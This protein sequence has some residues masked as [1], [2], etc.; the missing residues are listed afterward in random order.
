[1]IDPHDITNFNRTNGELQEFLLFGICAAGK[2]AAIQA[3][4]LADF[5]QLSEGETPFEKV[6]RMIA[7]GSLEDNLRKVKL[8]KYRI[9]EPGFR[10]LAEDDPDLETISEKGLMQYTGIGQKT[11]KFFLLHSREDVTVA[12]LDTHVLAWLRE[13]GY[14]DAPRQPRSKKEYDFYERVFLNEAEM[15]GQHPA[16]LDLKIWKDRARA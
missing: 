12:C 16:H 4:K 1:M 3:E 2:T 5:L 14:E 10:Q 6:R 7:N 8:G 15:R 9:L 13:I 11:A